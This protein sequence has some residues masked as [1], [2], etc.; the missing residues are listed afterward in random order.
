VHSVPSN[1]KP[2]KARSPERSNE[3]FV[4]S[5]ENEETVADKRVV[6]SFAEAKNV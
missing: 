4:Q 3:E 2:E 6:S 5:G 1:T